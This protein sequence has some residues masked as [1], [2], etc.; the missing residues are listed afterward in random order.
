MA[1][2]VLD[3]HRVDAVLAW[4]ARVNTDPSV[5]AL[6]MAP[7]FFPHGE[8]FRGLRVHQVRLAAAIPPPTPTATGADPLRVT[9]KREQVASVAAS[10][11]R[12]G[13]GCLERP[14]SRP[15]GPAPSALP[16]SSDGS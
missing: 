15:R 16:A 12:F 4:M 8:D 3:E 10:L 9:T 1:E 5:G 6:T 13:M 14:S 7:R 2:L 11:T